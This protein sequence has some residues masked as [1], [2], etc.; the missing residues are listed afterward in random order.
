[1]E[2]KV[3]QIADKW[4]GIPLKGAAQQELIQNFTE[5]GI[6]DNKRKLVNTFRGCCAVFSTYGI[7]L[8]EKQATKKDIEQW[9]QYLNKVR[10]K[11]KV[12]E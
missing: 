10:E 1:M 9:P 7:E 5:M 2:Q 8:K 4:R 11:F 6:T 3:K 12:I